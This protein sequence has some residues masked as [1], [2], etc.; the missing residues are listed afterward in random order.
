MDLRWFHFLYG[1]KNKGWI[2]SVESNHWDPCYDLK[3]WFRFVFHFIHLWS[4]YWLCCLDLK[5]WGELFCRM[6]M[7]CISLLH[8]KVMYPLLCF[9]QRYFQNSPQ[10]LHVWITLSYFQRGINALRIL[11]GILFIYFFLLSDVVQSTIHLSLL[12][13][14]SC[15]HPCAFSLHLCYWCQRV[16]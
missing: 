2:F 7:F 8:V 9:Q 6:F 12:P 13:V 10:I 4:L 5:W 15:I 11:Q 16:G 14:F 3:V 1:L